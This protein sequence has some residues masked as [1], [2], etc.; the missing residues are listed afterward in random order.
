MN[1]YRINAKPLPECPPRTVERRLY[2]HR[3]LSLA[4]VLPLAFGVVATSEAGCGASPSGAQVQQAITDGETLAAC[5]LGDVL[6]GVTDPLAITQKCVGAVPAVIADVV[7]MFETKQVEAQ[8]EIADASAPPDAGPATT[9]LLAMARKPISD[10]ERVL[11]DE[12]KQKAVALLA[13]GK[14]H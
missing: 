13:A 9:T 1:T 12:A 2:P 3:V 14:A 6:G 7:S 5:I 10:R 4:I 11:L 8:K